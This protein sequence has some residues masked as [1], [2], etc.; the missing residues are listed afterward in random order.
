MI[1]VLRQDA[2]KETR[3]IPAPALFLPDITGNR[4]CPEEEQ[5]AAEGSPTRGTSEILPDRRSGPVIQRDCG[6][7]TIMLRNADSR[8]CMSETP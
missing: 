4:A 2:N 1:P 5:S 3:E 7:Q 6:H 8:A